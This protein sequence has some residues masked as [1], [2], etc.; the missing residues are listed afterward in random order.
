MV[1]CILKGVVMDEVKVPGI[2]A[3]QLEESLRKDIEQCIAAV[4]QAVDGARVGAIIDES[5]EPVREATGR[6]RQK[7]FEKAI[8]MK[9][10][11]AEAAF[12]PSGR[13]RRRT[14]PST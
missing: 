1:V 8:Q 14:S 5:E 4:V 3:K 2:D 13:R 11:A 6:L 7:I 9:T 12:S 10:D